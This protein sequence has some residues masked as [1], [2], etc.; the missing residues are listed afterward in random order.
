MARSLQ[1]RYQRAMNGFGPSNRS[2]EPLRVLVMAAALVAAS[3]TGAAI[4]FLIDLISADHTQETP[5]P[6]AS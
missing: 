4:G 5:A 6:P 1:R 2:G 3:I